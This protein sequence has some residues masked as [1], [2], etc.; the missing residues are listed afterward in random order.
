LVDRCHHLGF[1]ADVAENGQG[2]AA[3]GADLVGGGVD[4]ALEFRMRLRRF[5]RDRDIGAVAR[6]AQRDREPDATACA[7]D[8]QRLAFEGSH[9]PTPG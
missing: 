1:L 2:L 9:E 8:E 7:G 3:R 6:G 4:R 5:R